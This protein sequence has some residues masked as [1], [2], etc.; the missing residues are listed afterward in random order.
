MF[1]PELM[2]SAGDPDCD[3]CPYAVV[4]GPF[5]KDAWTLELPTLMD[6][7]VESHP[8][9]WIVQAIGVNE[10]VSYPV[11]LP[12]DAEIEGAMTIDAYDAP[13]YDMT[14]DRMT[15]FRNYLE[16]FNPPTGDQYMHNVGHDWVSG[17]WEEDG[18]IYVGTMEP[19]DISPSDPAFFLHHCN[20]DRLWAAWQSRVDGRMDAYVPESGAQQGWNRD[21][22]MYP[23]LLFADVPEIGAANTPGDF[24]D[25]ASLGYTYED[26]LQ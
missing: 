1:S 6:N 22:E 17:G 11:E 10:N 23:Y 25:F 2:G 5:R 8:W 3:G 14:V 16:G 13:P 7:Y 24:L 20:A 19:L 26:L 15:S 4:D 18:Q 21:D 12:T 9:T